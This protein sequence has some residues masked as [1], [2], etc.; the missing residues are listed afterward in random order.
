MLKS[1]AKMFEELH[2][3]NILYCHW[4][5]NEHLEP[6]L[7]GE[8]DLD[9]LFCPDDRSELDILLNK[10]GLKR[11]RATPLSQYNAIEDYIGFD[12]DE[13]KIWHLHLHY[14]LT[15]G[16]S[17]LKGYTLGRWGDCLLD[18]RILHNTGV[19]ISCPEDE[20]VLLL[21]RIALKLSLHT[22][23]LKISE[24]DKREINWLKQNIKLHEFAIH[25]EHLVGAKGRDIMVNI[26]SAEAGYRYTFRTL[27]KHLRKY[28]SC[29]TGNG[30]LE[31]WLKRELRTVH[32]ILGGINHRLHGNSSHPF[33]RVSPSG[34]CVIAF[35]GS[36]GAGK[37]TT[38]RYI[39]GELSKKLDVKKVYLGSGDGSCSLLRKPLKMVAKRVGGKGL[40]KAVEKEYKTAAEGKDKVSV[41]AK[42]YMYAKFIWAITLAWEKK[43]KL[44]EITKARNNGMVVLLDRY[45]QCSVYGV[46][47]G[48]LLH[49]YI[50]SC[51][52]CL[53][54]IAQYEYSIYKMFEKN[55]PDLTIRLIAP[56]EIA[57][58]RKSEM[59]Q[60]E[61][62]KKLATVMAMK[63][64]KDIVTIDTAVDKKVS[65][66][67]VMECI[68]GKV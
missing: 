60:E 9:M 4:K 56:I 48:P 58:E 59:T 29:F 30:S 15:L 68:W 46:N 19:Y 65:F 16:E 26:I 20:L 8:T 13:A 41:K 55:P 37:S 44:K 50:D 25:A 6:A 43:A 22:M 62:Q 31:A 34:G 28:L 45:P 21:T 1:I 33:S 66:G 23:W 51:N 67:K 5:S 40:G 27:A 18:N 7:N 3:N 38:I 47:D 10:C 42:L 2:D 63:P 53:K 36:D 24:D 39:Q 52:I 12:K 61:L 11:F 35:I 57:I 17:H 49:S 32:W 14:R 64:S 54:S